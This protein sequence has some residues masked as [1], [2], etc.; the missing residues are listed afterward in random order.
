MRVLNLAVSATLSQQLVDRLYRWVIFVLFV[1]MS[2]TASTSGND[3]IFN[4]CLR[5]SNHVCWAV[6]GHRPANL[7]GY[8]IQFLYH[9][10]PA[11]AVFICRLRHL[12]P[13]P[14]GSGRVLPPLALKLVE[15]SEYHTPN[16]PATRHSHT[17]VLS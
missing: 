9:L 5:L 8:V 10:P 1:E 4:P 11:I 14:D 6:A 16:A 7:P 2:P 12:T 13:T 17:S 15:F 3:L